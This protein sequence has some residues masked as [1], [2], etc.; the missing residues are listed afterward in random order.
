[1]RVIVT[2][3]N[4]QPLDCA[5]FRLR[6]MELLVHK[7][8]FNLYRAVHAIVIDQNEVTRFQLTNQLGHSDACF[9]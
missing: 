9:S 1:V 3:W 4:N 7:S 5:I 2:A 6:N 8:M